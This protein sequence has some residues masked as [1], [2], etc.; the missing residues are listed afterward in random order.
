MAMTAA[1]PAA[2]NADHWFG[3]E[4]LEAA[5]R[6]AEPRDPRARPD[7]LPAGGRRRRAAGA[8]RGRAG[9]GGVRLRPAG[10]DAGEFPGRRADAGTPGS[11]G[12]AASEAGSRLRVPRGTPTRSG[13]WT[14]PKKP[15]PASA[16]TPPPC[17]GW[18]GRRPLRD[19]EWGVRC[20]RLS[21]PGG[22]AR[23]RSGDRDLP[24]RLQSRSARRRRGSPFL[25]AVPPQPDRFRTARGAAAGPVPLPARRREPDDE[26]LLPGVAAGDRHPLSRL[27]RPRIGV[28]PPPGPR[29]R[30]TCLRCHLDPA[31]EHRYEPVT[32]VSDCVGCHMPE[33]AEVFPGA[34]FTDH[35]I[36]V[37]GLP[38]TPDSAATVADL[39]HLEVLHRNELARDPRDGRRLA[40]LGVGLGELLLAQGIGETAFEAVERGLSGRPRYEDLLKA[41][42]LYRASGNNRRAAEILERAV[43]EEPGA[44]QA[45]FDLGDLRLAEGDAE[46]A[47]S[48]LAQAD[49]LDP[50]SAIVLARLGDAYRAAGRLDE[51]LAAGLRAVEADADAEQ[52]WLALGGIRRDR[53]ETALAAEALREAHRLAPRWP[54]GLAALARLLALDPDEG[55]ARSGRG[56]APGR[57]A[58]RDGRLPGAA[59]AG[60][61]GR[62]PCGERRFPPRHSNRRTGPGAGAG[63]RRTGPHGSNLHTARRLPARPTVGGAR[64]LPP[65]TARGQSTTAFDRR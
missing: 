36:R 11:R 40:R 17:D 15:P 4:R 7:A 5:G 25:R 52:A 43:S 34:D 61:V 14:R 31:S 41:A 20:E 3:P 24:P 22:G 59:F 8:G 42:A 63:G 26:R 39:R 62:G 37:D 47:V 33:R 23:C 21:R 16:A 30:T 27:P 60:P 48:A 1:A 44:A 13:R 29:S 64:S 53:R 12:R 56:A 65:L 18:T 2:D 38:P 6:V 45:F 50:D 46:G 19:S 54:P 9:G 28:I 51:A 57:G 49:R 10:L 55:C 35:W 32:A 58:G